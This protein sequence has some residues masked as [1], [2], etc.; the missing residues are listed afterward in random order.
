MG[1]IFDMISIKVR[2]EQWCRWNCDL[3]VINARKYFAMTL[4]IMCTYAHYITLGSCCK[5]A[6]SHR[7]TNLEKIQFRSPRMK[8]QWLILSFCC[9]AVLSLLSGLYCVH[10]LRVS[11]LCP[12]VH[13]HYLPPL[14]FQKVLLFSL[15][16][17]RFFFTMRSFLFFILGLL[18]ISYPLVS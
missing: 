15:S 2:W 6:S 1:V 9:P 11:S 4:K 5:M 7:V 13:W 8:L 3:R 14:S 10:G 16:L 18:A 17:L 12:V